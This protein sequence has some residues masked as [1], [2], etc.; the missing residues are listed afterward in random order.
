MAANVCEVTHDFKHNI[1]EV[2]IQHSTGALSERGKYAHLPR[3]Q[4]GRG[5]IL[6]KKQIRS[7]I[8]STL[9]F[10][11]GT[12]QNLQRLLRSQEPARKS[13]A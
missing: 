9:Y 11:S 10:N 13:D 3:C 2:F 12:A 5:I 4:E 1:R 8:V 7:S 6:G